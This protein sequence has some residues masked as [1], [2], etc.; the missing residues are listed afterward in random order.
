M[1]VL[2]AH[3][4]D[5]TQI[6]EQ[7]TPHHP[8]TQPLIILNCCNNAARTLYPAAPPLYGPPA[9][10]LCLWRLAL[11]PSMRS[12]VLLLALV[13]ALAVLTEAGLNRH[14]LSQQPQLVHGERVEIYNRLTTPAGWTRLRPA[15]L[16]ERLSFTLAVKGQNADKLEQRFWAVSDPD[17]DSFGDFMT[18]AEI[19]Q[20]VAPSATEL[21][22]IYA[23]LAAHGIS[24]EQVVSHGDS[25]DVSC[26]VAQAELLFATRFFYF[27]HRTGQHVIRQFGS[28]SLPAQLAEQVVMVFN[29][30]TFPTHEQRS[31]MSAERKA[32][33]AAIAAAHAAAPSTPC[34]VPQAIASIYGLPFPIA[35]MSTPSVTAGVIEWSMQ[36]FSQS[37]LMNFSTAVAVPLVPVDQHR[38]IGNNSESPYPGIEAELDIQ[39]AHN[40]RSTRA[41]S[42]VSYC[43][44]RCSTIVCAHSDRCCLCLL[45]GMAG[46]SRVSTPASL[47]GSGW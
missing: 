11:S 12:I 25:F 15:P 6:S 3:L 37:D 28:Y 38:I 31:H 42:H 29:V 39:S 24:A 45:D 27:A 23:T 1:L 17:N 33:Q 14:R 44:V 35:P 20:L 2:D 41:H 46:G 16:V 47:L 26:T 9:L 32:K 40:T 36:T 34:W 8:T 22:T 13:L 5:P 19:D 18:A 30:H 21:A 7:P 4:T 43:M 10:F